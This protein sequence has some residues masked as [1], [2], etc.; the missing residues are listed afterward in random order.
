MGRIQRLI[1]GVLVA[2]VVFSG[3]ATASAAARV[4][5]LP[6]GVLIGDSQGITVGYDG[7]YFIDAEDLKAGDVI[8]KR[9]TIENSEPYS[10][11]ISM[12]AEPL[13]ET[14]PLKL[15]DEVNCVLKL[16]GTV[17]Y[18]GRVRGSD[19]TDMVAHALS[20]GTFANGQQRT[21]DITLTVSP[22]MK[23]YYWSKSEA[24]FKWIFYANRPTPP[25][26]PLPKTGDF[27][28]AGLYTLIAASL[29]A[30]AVLLVL[31][32]RKHASAQR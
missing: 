31:L 28:R 1:T 26:Q 27:L 2:A 7:A 15:L 12:R 9:L 14:G 19:G 17:I 5:D 24:L 32:Q 25:A 23:T 29:L 20:L 6:P 21:L 13:S 4:S 3:T 8:T 18:D 22:A 30:T 16:D 11:D 10:Y